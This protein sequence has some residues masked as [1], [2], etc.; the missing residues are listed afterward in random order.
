[1]CVH[2]LH[3]VS[4]MAAGRLGR[5]QTLVWRLEA[6]VVLLSEAMVKRCHVIRTSLGPRVLRIL[7]TSVSERLRQKKMGWWS[8]GGKRG[9]EES[10]G[11]M[12]LG[13]GT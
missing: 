12:G 4:K 11:F 6:T 5:T 7:Q 13:G 3:S 8:D 2:S 1:M 10:A 9:G